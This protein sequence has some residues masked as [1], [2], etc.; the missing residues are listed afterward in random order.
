LVELLADDPLERTPTEV[1]ESIPERESTPE[2]IIEMEEGENYKF[3]EALIA[4][5]KFEGA[6]VSTVDGIRANYAT[7]WGLVRAS[8]TMPA[9]T[10]RFEANTSEKLQFMKQQFK[11][12]MLQVKP[13]LTLDF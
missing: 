1:F 8:N 2:I 4:E 13:T 10:L 3:M 6:Q 5:A 11:Q 12:Q 7:G 9:L